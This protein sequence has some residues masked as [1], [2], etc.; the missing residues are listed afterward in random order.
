[1]R[2]ILI[3][4]VNW[5]GDA[6][7][8]TP[9]IGSIR[10]HFPEAE[11][12][13]LA[14]PLVAPLFSPH[15]WVDR[16]MVFDRSGKHRGVSGRFRLAAE[17]RKKGFDVAIILPNSFDSALVPWLAGIPVRLGKSSDGRRLLLTESYR[18]DKKIA[19]SHEVNYYLEL[20]RHFGISGQS[21][22][23]QLFTTPDEERA[24]RERL[25]KQGINEDYFVIGINP[26]AAYGSAKRWYPDR[27]AEV[28]RRLA[29]EWAAR[30]VIF[31]GSNETAIAADIER[32]LNGACLNLAGKTSVRELMT[33]IKRCN[34]LVT[35][36][37]GPMHIAAAFGV[38]LAAIFGPTDHTGT[39]PFSESSVI[40]REDT[41]CAPCKLREC[42]TDHRCMT[43]VTADT[44]VRAARDLRRNL[45]QSGKG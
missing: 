32:N 28:G 16:I 45:D 14:N 27:F 40:I 20:L 37:S 19:I 26:G 8:T 5:V 18:P 21:G 9:A 13:I 12:T 30:I 11:I 35:N 43:A 23:P 6:V 17:V 36:D 44:V 7:M 41:A 2:K 29:A 33:L 15:D 42:P 4:A 24:A 38:P 31:G 34:F 3:R 22:A 10:Q 1:M 25:A 39:A